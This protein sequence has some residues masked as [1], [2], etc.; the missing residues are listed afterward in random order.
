MTKKPRIETLSLILLTSLL[1]IS[2]MLTIGL[3]SNPAELIPVDLQDENES[4]RTLSDSLTCTYSSYLGGSD[5]EISDRARFGIAVDDDGNAFIT[6]STTSVDFPT[7]NAFQGTHGGLDDVFVTKIAENG[8]LLFSTFLGGSGNDFG[9]NIAV[10]S[11][12]N[13]FVVGCTTSSNFPATPS[14]YQGSNGGTQDVFVAKFNN[15]GTLLASTFLGGSDSEWSYAMTVDS[16]GNVI[17]G[18]ETFSD[19]MPLQN[20]YQTTYEGLGDT[21][22]AKIDGSLQTLSFSTYLGGYQNEWW[23]DVAVD[24]DDN[25]ILN[26]ASL[27]NDFPI[28]EDVVQDDFRGVADAIVTKLSSDGQTLI[29][30]T[31]LGSTQFDMGTGVDVDA[32][33]NIALTGETSSFFPVMQAYQQ[34]RGHPVGESECYVT[35]L[36]AN[37]SMIFSTY[38]SGSGESMGYDAAFDEYGNI[39]VVGEA[40]STSF[41]IVNPYQENHGGDGADLDAFVAALNRTGSVLFSTY[42]GGNNDDSARGVAID[43]FGDILITGWTTS[44]D[45]LTVNAFQGNNN[46]T[47]DIFI[48]KFDPGDLQTYTPESGDIT[49]SSP[50]TATTTDTSTTGNLGPS[51]QLPVELLVVPVVLIVVVLIIFIRRR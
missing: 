49:P 41:P 3:S 29:F 9:T 20:A 46:G 44:S 27:S 28:T 45:F 51:F 31:Y 26:G 39:I 19:D 24:Q 37:G 43:D 7:R 14:V 25:I 22:V 35:L 8:T 48:S 16:A 11:D 6:G 34:T 30:S 5:S 42:L 13:I 40:T 23:V 38:F 10:D 21:F 2:G 47:E 36:R 4:T 12:G 18:G 33:G 32:E 50:T 15:S 1:C 17:I